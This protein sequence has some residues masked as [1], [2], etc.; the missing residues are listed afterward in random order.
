MAPTKRTVTSSTPRRSGSTLPPGYA[1]DASQPLMLRYE[2]SLPRL[3]VPP[4][5]STCAK[6]LESVRPHVTD[7]QF[8]KTSK[9]VESFLTSPMAADLQ[10]RLQA[11]AAEPEIKNWLA[12]WWNDVAYMAYRDPVVVYVR[13]VAFCLAVTGS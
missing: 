12:D 5:E 10:K 4:L 2:A 1:E 13:C 11:R 6:Y 9:A 3:P 8:A 7:E